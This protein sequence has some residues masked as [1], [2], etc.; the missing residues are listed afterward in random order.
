MQG[1][2][3]PGSRGAGET[4]RRGDG[5]KVEH[6]TRCVQGDIEP[7]NVKEILKITPKSSIPAETLPNEALPRDFLAFLSVGGVEGETSVRN[8]MLAAGRAI[9]ATAAEAGLPFSIVGLPGAPPGRPRLRRLGCFAVA[10]AANVVAL[11]SQSKT[12]YRVPLDP[13]TSSPRVTA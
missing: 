9:L 12:R 2:G 13:W 8:N 7:R 1:D 10:A 11:R 3:E 5:H 6:S 4:G